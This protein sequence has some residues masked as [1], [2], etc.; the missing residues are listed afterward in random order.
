MVTQAL[1]SDIPSSSYLNSSGRDFFMDG[2][3]I[4]DEDLYNRRTY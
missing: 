4:F 2:D 3:N 1:F